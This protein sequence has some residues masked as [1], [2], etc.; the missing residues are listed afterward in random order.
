MACLP[1]QGPSTF[2]STPLTCPVSSGIVPPSPGPTHLLLN[3]L[4]LPGEQRHCPADG[5]QLRRQ[6]SAARLGLLDARAEVACYLQPARSVDVTLL[7]HRHLGAQGKQV[8]L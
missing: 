4:D 6:L 5:R 1:A 3:S 7:Q 2:F 8:L